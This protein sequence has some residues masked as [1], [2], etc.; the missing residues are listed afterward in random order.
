MCAYTCDNDKYKFGQQIF[1]GKIL[2]TILWSDGGKFQ[3]NSNIYK[4]L[5]SIIFYKFFDY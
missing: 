1:N 4:L 5:N 2:I 3:Q